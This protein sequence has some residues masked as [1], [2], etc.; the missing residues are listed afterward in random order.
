MWLYVYNGFFGIDSYVH[1]SDILNMMKGQIKEIKE[2][3]EI[4]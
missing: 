1:R 3:K 4:K 2:I